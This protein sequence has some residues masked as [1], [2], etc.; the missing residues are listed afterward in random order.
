MYASIW[1]KYFPVIRILMKK[2]VDSEQ[3]L[4]FNHIDFERTG[5]GR[6]AGYK[7]NI[8][9][10]DGKLNSNIRDNELA[11]SLVTELLEDNIT[12]ML[13]LQNNYEFSFN[14]KLQLYIKNTKKEQNY[15][16]NETNAEVTTLSILS[17][18]ENRSE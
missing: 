6:K 3:K 4:D 16:Q 14:T 18:Q 9:F 10:I 17:E 8:E 5:R 2:S 12:K 7:F 11:A 15:V 1:D 13:L